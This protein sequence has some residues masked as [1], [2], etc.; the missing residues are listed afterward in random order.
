M[1]FTRELSDRVTISVV[2]HGHSALILLLAKQLAST[3]LHRN[4]TLVIT[5]NSLK[6][7]SELDIKRLELA[8]LA[9]VVLLRN[10]VPMGFGANH[11]QAFQTCETEF[12]CI[13]N[14]DIEL[15]TEPFAQLL[16]M[17]V[18]GDIG[19][20]YPRQIDGR[21]TSLDFERHLVSPLSIAQRHL[22]GKRY[23]YNSDKPVDWV[24]GSF[25]VFRSAVFRE[26]G[27]FDDRYFM[28]CE[29]VDI[30]LRMQ[31]LGYKLARANV[32]VTHDTQR[33]TL[34]NP[35]HLAWHIRSLLRLWN[36]SVY[37]GYK[38]KLSTSGSY[39]H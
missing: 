36:S 8:S 7:D 22:F 24:S 12:F 16:K 1:T 38:K 28:Y 18:V 14:P 32:T 21:N 5:I 4:I 15:T 31:L 9:N 17:F 10:N 30:C 39:V 25:M 26:L 13:I 27:G 37:K 33:Q 29:D 6:L 23:R 2:S 19:L 3:P 11:N 34:K 35:R 20:T